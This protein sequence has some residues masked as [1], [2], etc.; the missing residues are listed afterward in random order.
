MTEGTVEAMIAKCLLEPAFLDA[1]RADATNALAAYGLDEDIRGQMAG[2]D[3]EKIGRFAGFIGKVQHNHLWESFPCTRHL[4]RFYRI[5]GDVFTAF[6]PQQLAQAGEANR[7]D[8][9]RR[10]VAFLDAFVAARAAIGLDY[11]G[12][13]ELLRHE[14][15]VW[16]LGLAESVPGP[17]P[18]IA[19][20]FLSDMPWG[21]FKRLV[22][23]R[24][25][26]LRISAFAADPVAIQG[27]VK[28][29]SFDGALP[30]KQRM[31]LLY[32]IDRTSAAMKLLQLDD[33]SG[34]VLSG[35]DDR[36]S[37]RAV[38]DR[39]RHPSLM[40]VSPLAF[41]DLFEEAVRLGFLSLVNRSEECARS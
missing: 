12:V 22:P 7:D 21:R 8:R 28:D 10:F 20:T 13:A 18:A 16:E 9:I 6:R 23:K 19:P 29:G 5:E 40:E 24:N 30:F 15:N 31:V 25:G 35:V 1:L 3:F 27:L 4:L 36:R 26:P 11:P 38:I 37:V 41:R 34:L 39:A 14:L 17:G 2:A 33:L 32:W